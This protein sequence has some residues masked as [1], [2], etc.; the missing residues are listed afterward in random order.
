MGTLPQLEVI[1]L[2]GLQASG[3][4]TFYRER[5][6]GTHLLI[7]K[8]RMKNRRHKEEHQ[9]KLLREALQAGRSVVLDNT[10]P[11]PASRAASIGIARSFGARVVAYYFESRLEE[12][13][14]RNAVREGRERVPDVGI[15]SAYKRLTSPA[16][17]EGFDRIYRV[18]LRPGQGFEVVEHR[19]GDTDY[20]ASI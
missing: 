1:L 14:A 10:H 7:S 17:S 16:R 15:F 12:C 2:I 11:D 19:S 5:F 3:K 4:S 8:D 20:S 13:L 6:A 18:R 9:Q